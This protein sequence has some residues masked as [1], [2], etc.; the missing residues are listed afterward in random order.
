MT[1]VEV[2]W[3]DECDQ[4]ATHWYNTMHYLRQASWAAKDHADKLNDYTLTA[5]KCVEQTNLDDVSRSWEVQHQMYQF[6]GAL[7]EEYDLFVCPTT[8]VPTVRADH[9][10]T[11]RD[12][13]ID[14]VVVDPEYGWVLTHHFNM[15]HFC[16]VMAVPSGV[17][18]TGV[19]TGIQIVGRTFD[20][21]TVF[22]ASLAYEAQCGGWLRS[23]STRPTLHRSAG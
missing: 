12:F 4:A 10:P 6:F 17:A 11:S 13:K 19:T 7:M 18:S 16:P 9:D 15:L 2:P 8:T 20:D 14:G 22:K 5:A 21:P 23:P 1:E 3:S